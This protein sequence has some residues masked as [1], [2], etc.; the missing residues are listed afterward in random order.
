MIGV[1][2]AL[3]VPIVDPSRYQMPLMGAV[4]TGKGMSFTLSW[5]S[6]ELT[7]LFPYFTIFTTCIQNI[8]I[9]LLLLTKFT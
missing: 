1:G 7:I 5:V 2:Q 4:G 8:T 9:Y 6:V 3:S